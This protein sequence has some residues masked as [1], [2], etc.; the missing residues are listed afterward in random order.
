MFKQ[1]GEKM[2]KK[3][4]AIVSLSIIGVLIV[5]TVIFANVKIN[6]S[7][8]CTTPDKI[9]VQTGSNSAVVVKDENEF[10]E[11]KKYI[12]NA[13]KEVFISA[14]FNGRLKQKANIVSVSETGKT[15]PTADGFYVS[16]LYSNPQVLKDGKKDYKD[17]QGNKY[18][19]RELV[20]D[21]TKSEGETTV[22]VYVKPY[23][24]TTGEKADDDKYTKY[25]ELKADFSGLY[26]YLADNFD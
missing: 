7:I 2:A 3:I 8:K 11:I 1:K 19:Y 16:Y 14:M 18:Y 22:K 13:S 26:N 21:V 15:M 17:S 24:K 12:D 5:L 10:N 4:G 23:Y 6:Y 25:Y 20:F 9:Y